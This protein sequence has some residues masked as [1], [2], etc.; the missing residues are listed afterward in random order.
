MSGSGRAR[1]SP[2]GVLTLTATIAILA[3]ALALSLPAQRHSDQLHIPLWVLWAGLVVAEAAVL[4]L[5]VRR[6]SLLVSATP[7]PVVAGLLF[8]EPRAFVACV[9]AAS[10]TALLWRRNSPVKAIFNI[11]IAALDAAV[12]RT[13]FELLSGDAGSVTPQAA[14]AVVVAVILAA[15]L[16][17][18]AINI[19]FYLSSG[20]FDRTSVLESYVTGFVL[21]GATASLGLLVAL[22]AVE[23]PM[24]LVPLVCIVALM[25]LG[26]RSL[27]RQAWQIRRLRALYG[28]TSAVGGAASTELVATAILRHA[29]DILHC[30]VAEIVLPARTGHA[31]L[32]LQVD[33]TGELVRLQ[34][35]WRTRLGPDDEPLLTGR[36]EASSTTNGTAPS[37]DAMSAAL[38][39]GGAVIGTLAVS[40]RWRY[41]PTF[42]QED[43]D[44]FVS[45]CDHAAVAL[46]ST[47]L[48][49]RVQEDATQREYQALHDSVAVLLNRRGLLESAD[50]LVAQ[51]EQELA[52][53]ALDIVGFSDINDTLGHT[54]GDL[55]LRQVGRR[56]TDEV[57]AGRVAR[58]GNDDF[59]VLLSDSDGP[60]ALEQRVEQVLA[61][62]VDPFPLDQLTLEISVNA[63]W[64]AVSDAYADTVTLLQ[65]ADLALTVAKRTGRRVHGHDAADDAR[66]ARRLQLVS[67]LRLAV[68]A[69]ALD[70]HYQPK[71]DPRTGRVT[72][73]E[74]LARWQHPVEGFVPPDEF[75]PLAEHAGL[76]RA[77]TAS[78]LRAS[79]AECA[80]WR[81][82]GHRLT[83]AVNL[84]PRVLE[85]PALPGEVGRALEAAGLPPS[86]LILEVT[87]GAVMRDVDLARGILEQL[88]LMGVHLSLDDFG[89]GHSS[90]AYLA[91]LPVDELKLDKSFTMGLPFDPTASA[92]VRSTIEL[93]HHLG[94]VIVAE[95]VE[96][97]DA[98]ALLAQWGCDVVQGYF[99]SRPLPADGFAAWMR[100]RATATVSR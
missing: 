99:Y 89:T 47:L 81:A 38:T 74:A 40:D 20:R 28:F 22:L 77:L 48:L 16:T 6:N 71:L 42:S 69:D 56:L 10:C 94:L 96:E 39:T 84:S 80:R 67:D 30:D 50:N 44:L 97:E 62:L 8:V 14:I 49:E 57:G 91:T 7:V 61:V 68:A 46:N 53:V 72:G 93:G 29:R 59:A 54:V 17:S 41:L 43:L 73:C 1:R 4:H 37:A 21:D 76:I 65:R 83:V 98:R 12:A 31:P 63:G 92:I 45:L 52:F 35:T 64:A 18:T 32:V 95:G 34:P 75:I 79:L 100:A 33:R 24:G 23:V 66:T 27:S 82:D 51:G 15:A 85:D 19:A 25:L 87:E 90:L 55:L 86:A 13:V 78:V 26:A 2:F 36:T 58:L 9:L 60:D 88:R 70:V 11:C 5:N 3:A